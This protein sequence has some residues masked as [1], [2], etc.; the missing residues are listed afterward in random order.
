[1]AF[2]ACL[3]L[4]GTAEATPLSYT[5]LIHSANECIDLDR[6]QIQNIFENANTIIPGIRSVEPWEWNAILIITGYFNS[7][8]PYDLLD[9]DCGAFGLFHNQPEYGIR[10][11][12]AL[13][14]NAECPIDDDMVWVHNIQNIIYNPNSLPIILENWR[15]IVTPAIVSAER[16]N[17]NSDYEKT[18]VAS[19]ANSSPVLAI[20]LMN[21]CSGNVDCMM[22]NY[23][24]YG[25]ENCS[26][27]YDSFIKSEYSVTEFFDSGLCSY[28]PNSHKLGRTRLIENFR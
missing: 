7:K 9:T 19:I 13:T 5:P 15:D 21:D 27:C 14:S 24:C 3:K 11:F 1:M 18:V 6:D 17:L 25:S 12:S 2:A 28:Q 26:S 8:N 10:T 16:F 22:F 23:S 20:N 4:A